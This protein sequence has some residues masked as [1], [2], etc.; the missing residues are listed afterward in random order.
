MVS[1]NGQ[2]HNGISTCIFH[3]LLSSRSNNEDQILKLKIQVF[4]VFFLNSF[5]ILVSDSLFG[6]FKII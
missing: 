3:L 2:M 1:V 5:K 4:F 6:C